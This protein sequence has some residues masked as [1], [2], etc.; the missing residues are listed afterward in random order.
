MARIEAAVNGE[1][2]AGSRYPPALQAS[3]DTERMPQEMEAA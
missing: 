3:V 2:V 1:T